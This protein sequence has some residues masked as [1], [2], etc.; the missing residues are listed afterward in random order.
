MTFTKQRIKRYVCITL[1]SCGYI[2]LRI[3]YQ[4]GS[5]KFQ[6]HDNPPAFADSFAKRVGYFI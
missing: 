6:P 4:N 1:A 5:P 2:A 3:W